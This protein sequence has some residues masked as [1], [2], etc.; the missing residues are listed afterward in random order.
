MGEKLSE[1]LPVKKTN[2]SGVL[3][4]KIVGLNI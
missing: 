4:I 2:K 1:D 3:R